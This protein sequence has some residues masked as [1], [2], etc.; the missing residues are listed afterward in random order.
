MQLTFWEGLEVR[1]SALEDERLER[2][3]VADGCKTVARSDIPKPS[4]VTLMPE[5]VADLL[6]ATGAACSP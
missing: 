5:G 6:A 3:A 2:S 4:V 1:W